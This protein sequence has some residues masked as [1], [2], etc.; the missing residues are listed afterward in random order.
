GN[1]E[2]ANVL[3]ARGPEPDAQTRERIRSKLAEVR[4]GR[5]RPAPD[6][7]VLTSWN[8]LAIAAFA[9]AGAVLGEPRYRA[10]ARAAAEFLLGVHRDADGRLLRTSKDGDARLGAY[11]E[12]HA[13]LVEAL[14]GLYEATWEP[15]WLAAARELADA[16]IARF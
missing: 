6:D 12:D 4:A 11:L 7:K 13:F 14:I 9:D 3:E 15:R 5:V 8:A 10:A 16:M 1:F 2:G